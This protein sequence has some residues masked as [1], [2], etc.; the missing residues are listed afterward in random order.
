M[1]KL[2]VANWKMQRTHN[3]AIKW[4]KKELPGVLDTLSE[5]D[6]ELVICPSFTELPYATKAYPDRPW[7][8][9][10]CGSFPKGAFTGEISPRSL[11]DLG[12]AFCIVGHSERRMYNGETDEDVAQKVAMIL[13]HRMHPIVCVGETA[14]QRLHR[15][16]ILEQQL[17]QLPELCCRPSDA[18]FIAYEPVW[19]IGTGITPTPDELEDALKTI[20]LLT[21]STPTYI[22]YGGS[23]DNKNVK[24]YSDLVDGFLIGSASLD[25]ELLKKII[26]SC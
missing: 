22:L 17:E 3:E 18:L 15:D 4:F 9:Q 26:L 14:E 10:D 13:K 7:G 12:I 19:A 21:N 23:V 1:D 6:H 20:K 24:D 16:D 2:L 8:A 25:S 11:E 5:T